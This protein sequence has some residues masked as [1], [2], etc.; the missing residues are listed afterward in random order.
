MAEGKQ[1]PSNLLASFAV[2]GI[3]LIFASILLTVLTNEISDKL[4]LTKTL[5]GAIF[6]GVATSV[7]ELT[8]SLRLFKLKNYNIAVGNIVGSN[9]FNF[10]ILVVADFVTVN[11]QIYITP[12]EEVM[13]LMVCGISAVAL[14]YIMLKYRNKKTQFICPIAIVASYVAFLLV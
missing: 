11:K 6:L 14:F 9:L 3:A 13:K 10:L 4:E 2:T 7:P 1:R 5:S 12:G 8:T